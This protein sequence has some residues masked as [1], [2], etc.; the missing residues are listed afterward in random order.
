MDSQ[1]CGRVR[2]NG[3]MQTIEENVHSHRAGRQ[4]ARATSLGTPCGKGFA[5]NLPQISATSP[6]EP[7]RRADASLEEKA[8]R[9][10]RAT[11][12]VRLQRPPGAVDDLSTRLALDR[13][14]AWKLVGHELG[15]CGLSMSVDA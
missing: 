2:Q 12:Q 6:I 4:G 5:Q 10:G 7:L 14:A 1:R 15:V 3:S 8:A 13:L 11:F 9:L